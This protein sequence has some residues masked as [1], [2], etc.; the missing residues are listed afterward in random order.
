M[1]GMG[2]KQPPERTGTP[3]ENS[4]ADRTTTG[5]QRKALPFDSTR[6][7][8]CPPRQRRAIRMLR[9]GGG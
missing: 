8:L 7:D 6:E 4:A 3:G 5:R 2:P 1:G 9:G